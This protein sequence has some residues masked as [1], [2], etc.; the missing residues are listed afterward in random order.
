MNRILPIVL[1]LLAGCVQLPPLPGDAQAKRFESIPDR[2]VIYVARHVHD[3]DFVAPLLLDDE[4]LGPTYRGTY[5]R[6]VVPAGEHRLARYAGD[7]GV[8]RF[9]TESGK[10]Y[11]IDQTTWGFR[12]L[13]RSTFELADPQYGRTL[14]LNGTMNDEVIR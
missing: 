7:H 5:L 3:K 14:V 6:I 4:W 13:D 1:M 10:L 11:F 8:I 2:A 12:S 9:V